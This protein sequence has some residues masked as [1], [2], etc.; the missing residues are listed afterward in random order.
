[1]YQQTNIE[2]LMHFLEDSQT[3]MIL[4]IE[5]MMLGPMRQMVGLEVYRNRKS[6]AIHL[7]QGP[8]ICKILTHFGM[9][10]ANPTHT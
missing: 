8:Y 9:N 2:G 10:S 7:F 5:K 1:M 4:M 3:H 6:K